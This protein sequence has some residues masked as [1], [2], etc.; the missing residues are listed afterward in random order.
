MRQPLLWAV[1]LCVALS[2]AHAEHGCRSP[3]ELGCQRC[4]IQNPT[5]CSISSSTATDGEPWYNR[6][7]H[8]D[9]ACEPN[10]KPCARCTERDQDVF[11][12]LVKPAG[13]ECRSFPDDD[14]VDPCYAL[15]SCECYCH[16]VAN[17]QACE[18]VASTS[19]D[20]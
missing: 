16:H 10:C 15:D 1:L 4:C 20:V 11:D 17:A 9:G 8:A 14:N 18:P 3:S 7:E 12:A 13:C 19:S 5:T 6:H 2:Q